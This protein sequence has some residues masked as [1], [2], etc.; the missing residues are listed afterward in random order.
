EEKLVLGEWSGGAVPGAEQTVLCELFEAQAARTPDAIAVSYQDTQ[1]TYAELNTRAN[2]LARHLITQGAG[3]EQRVAL[4]LPRS[5][6]LITAILAVTKA[7]AAFIPID[8]D[9]PAERI[10]LMLD[11]ARPALTLDHTNITAHT[12][13]HDTTNI[14]D[15][16]RHTPL[17]TTHPAYIIYT[18][19]STGRPKGVVITH[20]GLAN[21][22]HSQIQHLAVTPHSRIL[23]FA[24]TSFDAAISEICMALLSG[25]TLVLAPTDQ[26]RDPT[27]LT[28]LLT[29]HHITHATLPPALL[30]ALPDNALPPGMTLNTAGE[31]LP[32]HTVQR[33]APGR[34]MINAYGPTETTVCA[35]MSDPLNP[36]TPT[37]PPIGRPLGTTHLYVLDNALQPVPPT[38]PGEL[39]VAGPGL[40]RGYHNRPD[41]TAER[42]IPCPYTTP[43][44][45]MYRTGDIVRWHTNGTLEF[46]GRTDHQIKIRGYRI[47]PAEIENTLTHHTPI[48]HAIVTTREDHPGDKRLI[49]YITPQPHTTI[50][51]THT[52]TTLTRLL[53]DHMIPSTIIILDQ[54]PLTP[55]GK[56]DRHA[57]PAP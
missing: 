17:H 18:S 7:G 36:H 40:A 39:Y 30:A 16:E 45:R 4:L 35:T 27:H 53:P 5:T 48:T 14:T 24:P 56:I 1:L 49:A 20:T 13:A 33:W 38:I 3:P 23:Q 26:L 6:E 31:A 28:T 11:D 21:L 32:T 37:P 29:H 46:L 10:T 51:P 19:G 12:T 43:G 34:L 9:Y 54:P 15:T 42:F 57:L 52:R 50:D 25:A 47:E 44:E 22:A 55:A 41:L 8:P 2:H